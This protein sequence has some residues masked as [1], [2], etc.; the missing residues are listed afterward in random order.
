MG[1]KRAQ[2]QVEVVWREEQERLT[3][4]G[5]PVLKYRVTLPEVE[6]GGMGGRWITR[7]YRRLGEAWKKRWQRQV[8]WEACLDLARCRQAGLPFAAWS[9]ELRGEVTFL[10]DR[11]LSL[12]MTGEEVRSGGKLSM[13]RWGDTWKLREGAPCLPRELPGMEQNWKKEARRHV[14]EQGRARKAA[15]DFF[16]DEGWE[17]RVQGKLPRSALWVTEEGVEMAYPQSVLASAAEGVP[18]FRI[19]EGRKKMKVED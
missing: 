7:Y 6:R 16:P 14:L 2:K 10:D 11:L 18:S 13:A 8:Y 9:G 15:G 17:E 12:R 5:K 3:L 19:A 4:E 1:K